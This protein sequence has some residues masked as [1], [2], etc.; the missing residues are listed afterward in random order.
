[1]ESDAPLPV[2]EQHDL[3]AAVRHAL[4]APIVRVLDWW[5]EQV[6]GH[7][8]EA[9]LETTA[10]AGMCLQRADLACRLHRSPR[11]PYSARPNDASSRLPELW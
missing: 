9:G 10:V 4:V 8:I 11:E 6:T 1:V 2:L 5:W 3:L 7:P